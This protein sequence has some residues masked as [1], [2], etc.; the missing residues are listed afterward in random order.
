MTTTLT[1]TYEKAYKDG[2]ENGAL[3]LGET[4]RRNYQRGVDE[5]REMIREEIE[6]MNNF[7]Q[8][9]IDGKEDWNNALEQSA[10]K[11]DAFLASLSNKKNKTMRNKIMKTNKTS[12]GGAEFHALG[13]DTNKG[14]RELRECV[15]YCRQQN[16]MNECKNCGLDDA[17]ITEALTQAYKQGKIEATVEETYQY[18]ED[19][20]K[21]KEEAEQRTSK[22]EQLRCDEMVEK[23]KE[24][25]RY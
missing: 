12:I 4:A 1:T 8:A 20:K 17:M 7:R 21:A 15:E 19:M 18:K 5:T 9:K 13:Q 16:G 2:Y 14:E 23:A 22:L 25:G 11:V 10:L 24:G 6:K 3:K